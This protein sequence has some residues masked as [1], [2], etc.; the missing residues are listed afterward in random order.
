VNMLR[1]GMN[2]VGLTD[3]YLSLIDALSAIRQVSEVDLDRVSE[4]Q[5]LEQ[6]LGALIRHQD[7]EHC[8]LFLLKESQ[9][10]CAAGTGM[11]QQ[12]NSLGGRVRTDFGAGMQFS[13]GEGLVGIACSTGQIQYCRNCA[14]DER[15]KPFQSSGL[16]CE[17]GALLSVPVKS[18]EEVLGVLNISHPVPEFF[19][20]WHQHFLML[21]ANCLGRFLHIHRLLH[22][23]ESVVSERTLELEQALSESEDLRQR[24]Q[25]LSTTDELTGLHNRRFFFVEGESMLSRAI[26]YQLPISL[27]LM[28]LDYFKRIN[29]KWGHAAGDRI[30][31]LIS[32]V[33][34]EQVRSGDMVARLGGE[35]FVMLLP[36]TGVAGTD[37]MARRIKEKL[38]KLN[39]GGGMEGLNITV[40]IGMT[41]L[42]DG[43]HNNLS[44]TLNLLYT[45]ADTAMYLC[46][47]QGRNRRLFYMPEMEKSSCQN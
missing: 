44:E 37:L 23:L 6:A 39:L 26:R 42:D 29:D 5:L 18:G 46:K 22:N 3:S 13:L 17:R 7:L 9:L 20:A 28:D 31:K 43:I 16:F 24:Y 1:T 12:L 11:S 45:Q 2:V 32:G 25:H 38:G 47:A 30:L 10:Q 21:F 27:L 19:E 36:N 35:E 41:T 14:T 4:T 8:S 33:I 40:S 34:R 15:F